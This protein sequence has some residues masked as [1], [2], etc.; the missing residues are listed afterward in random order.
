MSLYLYA[1]LHDGDLDALEAKGIDDSPVLLHSLPPFAIAYSAAQQERYLAS[2]AN[3]LAHERAI[4]A[5]MAA[6]DPHR[7]VPLPLQFGL[8]VEDWGQ[9]QRDL[10]EGHQ[11]DLKAMLQKLAGKREVGV[12]IFWDRTQELNRMLDEQPALRQQ[13]DDLAGRLLSMDEAIAIGQALEA[14]LEARQQAIVSAFLGRLQPLSHAWTEGELMTDNMLWNAAFLIDWD[15]ESEFAEAVEA[16]DAQFERRFRIR[17]ND[18]TAP[19]NFA[20]LT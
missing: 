16:L 2:R 5:V 20:V 13:R 1:I 11:D 10:I 8:V 17:Y 6:V 19:F 18:F 15:R 7:V 9:V 4:E 12:K 3:L 14:A